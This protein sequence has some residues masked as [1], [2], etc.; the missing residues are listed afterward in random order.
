MR[1]LIQRV[2]RASVVVAG[3][4]IGRIDRG[5]LV[6]AAVKRGDTT[7]DCDW[8]AGKIAGLRVFPDDAGKM[9]RSVAE[10]GGAVLLVSQFTLYGDVRKGRRPSFTG[11]AGPEE[12]VP[13]LDALRERLAAVGLAVETGKFGAHMEVELLNDGPVTLMLDSEV[14]RSG[15][16]GGAGDGGAGRLRLVAGD[17]P[18]KGRHLVLA[19]GSPRRRE[20]LGNL[21]L[22]FLVDPSDAEENVDGSLE[23]REAARELARRKARDGATRHPGSFVIAADTLVTLDGRLYGKPADAGDATRMLRELSGRE[24]EVVTAVCV[25]HGESG[26]VLDRA[27]STRVRFRALDTDEIRRYVESGEPFGKAGAYAIQGRGG[28]LVAGIDGDYT[29]VVGLPIG[30]T[31]D[32]LEAA[33]SATTPATAPAPAPVPT[34]ADARSR[35]A[36]EG[37]P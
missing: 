23:P 8:I 6:L 32:L 34:R 2:S 13:M 4:T 22:T 17:S 18:L 24:H 15:R 10:A 25:A 1:A 20:M 9:N 28:L 12:A 14:R 27:V 21:G 11:S 26:L 5:L 29:N 30:D 37:S 16:S 35:V 36:P 7:D 3:E 31:L 19:S 33:V